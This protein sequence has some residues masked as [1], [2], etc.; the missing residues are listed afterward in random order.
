[1][2]RIIAIGGTVLVLVAAGLLFAFRADTVETSAAITIDA[3]IYD[4]WNTITDPD[5][6]TRWMGNVTGTARMKGEPGMPGGSLMLTLRVDQFS[7]A[8]YEDTLETDPPFSLKTLTTDNQGDLSVNSTYSLDSALDGNGTKLTITEIRDLTDT[9]PAWF[10]PFVKSRSQDQLNENIARL[11][12]LA[13]A[14]R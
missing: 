8:V 14:A 10:A 7:M 3:D 9:W 1:M 2:I 12:D 5:L 6:R 11:R 4:V 13:E